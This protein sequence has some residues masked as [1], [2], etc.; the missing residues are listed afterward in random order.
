MTLLPEVYPVARAGAPAF[1]LGLLAPRTS[2]GAVGWRAL[3]TARS[4]R[5]CRAPAG[6]AAR[7]LRS[8]T[9]GASSGSLAQEQINQPLPGELTLV[10]TLPA[11]R[12]PADVAGRRPRHRTDVL[13]P[14]EPGGR[15]AGR[16]RRRSSFVAPSTVKDRAGRLISAA[17]EALAGEP[18]RVVVT[19]SGVARQGCRTRCRRTPSSP[20][21]S[22]TRRSCARPRW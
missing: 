4:K 13:R 18:V 10:A 19:T 16:R 22:T 7:T 8:T 14:A 1:S 6:C 20:T 17:L 11:A 3:A 5:D 21:G 2:L 9:S 15:A 12:V